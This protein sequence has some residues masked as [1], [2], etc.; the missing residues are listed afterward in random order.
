[1]GVDMYE[2]EERCRP[3]VQSSKVPAYELPGV[4][5]FALLPLVSCA[6]NQLL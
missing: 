5:W 4:I 2:M 1:M 6:D 3:V